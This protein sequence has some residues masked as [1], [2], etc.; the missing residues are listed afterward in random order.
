MSES[1]EKQVGEIGELAEKNQADGGSTLLVPKDMVSGFHPT[2]SK[3][4]DASAEVDEVRTASRDAIRR[5][6]EREGIAISRSD[7]PLLLLGDERTRDAVAKD[8]ME[9]FFDPR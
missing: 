3:V 4:R 2:Q 5:Y 1:L 8:D 7:E 6:A 9:S